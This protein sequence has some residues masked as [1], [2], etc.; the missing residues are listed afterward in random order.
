MDPYLENPLF[1][2]DFHDRLIFHIGERLHDL[3]PAN[4]RADFRRRTRVLLAAREIVPDVAITHRPRDGG[5]IA[6]AACPVSEEATV[7]DARRTEAF[8]CYLEIIRVPERTLVAVI[9]VSSPTNKLSSEGGKQYQAKRRSILSSDVHLIEIDLLRSGPHWVAAPAEILKA[10]R[11]LDYV[12]CVSRSGN[13][14]QFKCYFKTV[15]QP[16]PTFDIP[17]LGPDDDCPV[18]LQFDAAYDQ[19]RMLGEVD[20]SRPLRP[21]PNA[22][23]RQWASRLLEESRLI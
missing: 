7:I 3:L 13:R 2:E 16:P 20:Y 21:P 11:P 17:L 19:G 18:G 4:Y 1:W 5:N 12:V 8:E 9:E 22:E 10:H 6:V 15:R 14:E 23:D